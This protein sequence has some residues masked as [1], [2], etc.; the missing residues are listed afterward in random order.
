M[1]YTSSPGARVVTP[2]PTS[3]TVPDTSQPRVNGGSPSAQA[4]PAPARVCQSTG[5]TP[6]ACTRT[7]TSVGSGTGR[8]AWPSV[9]TP[10][11]PKLCWTTAVIW[12]DADTRT[13][14][15]FRAP[16][17]AAGQP[18]SAARTHAILGWVVT[19]KGRRHSPAGKQ[20]LIE[21]GHEL[22]RRHRVHA[23]GHRYHRRDALS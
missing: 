2:K 4:T 13:S 12:A 5:F 14:G 15:S 1:P 7:R 8:A 19:R 22:C 10:G 20:L 9:S 11:A 16:D 3:S 6:A 17:A 23:V 21:R 18:C